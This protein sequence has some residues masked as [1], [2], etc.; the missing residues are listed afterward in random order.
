MACDEV[1]FLK[2]IQILRSYSM[3][4]AQDSVP[5]S[6]VIHPVVHKWMSHIQ[7]ESEKGKFL[8]LAVVILGSIVPSDTFP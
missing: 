1:Q 4:E 6:Y 5:G 3:V 2:A 7:N 8:S